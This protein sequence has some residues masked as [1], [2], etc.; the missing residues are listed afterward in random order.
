MAKEEE[1]RYGS[2]HLPDGEAKYRVI[3]WGWNGLNRTDEIDTGQLS[4]SFGIIADPP[5]LYP[6]RDPK[7]WSTYDEPISI[8]GFDDKLIVIFREDGKIKADVNVY[9]P[10]SGT[11]TTYQ[12]E[13]GN[14]LGTDEDFTP[15]SVVQFNVVDTS[16]GNIAAY[17]YDRRVLV[18][19][20]CF[21][22]DFYIN[23]M[24]PDGHFNTQENPIPNLRMA[25]V[26]GSRVF[27]VDEN[28]VYASAYNSY[29]D[30]SLDTADDV[31]SAH[32]WMSMSQSNTEA[33]GAFTAVASYDNHAVLFRKDFMQLV[34]N[35]KNPFRIVD[36]GE[37][38]CDN[39]AAVTH[40]GGALYFASRDKV[41]G[42]TGGTPKDV[43]KKL[44]AGDLSGCALGAWRDTLWLQCTSGVYTYKSGVWSALGTLQ[45]NGAD[46]TVKQFAALDYGLCAL[47]SNGKI[48]YLD[49]DANAMEPVPESGWD[50]SYTKDWWFET[51]LMAL[52]SL[53]VRRVKKCSLLCDGKEGAKVSAWLLTDGEK[54][55]ENRSVKVGEITFGEDGKRIMRVLTRQFSGIMHRLRIG[56]RG[57]VKIYAAEL[58]I[59]WGGELYVEG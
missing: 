13:V 41:Y 6:L 35:N 8:H 11:T 10:A 51:D 33:D 25:A 16:S 54:F 56:G 38:G 4:D 20:D 24:N 29:V 12:H 57:F 40:M 2:S 43:S 15:R 59:S 36:V 21:S 17:T 3:R 22:M 26:Y 58:K 34:Y 48:V 9:D 55:D 31:S 39:P 30:Y 18:Y 50:P 5:V 27:G 44:E 45:Y 49:W 46:V 37:Y 7:L 47:L 1:F 52:G 23:G 42:F 53:D 28:A 32:A 19:P 14:A